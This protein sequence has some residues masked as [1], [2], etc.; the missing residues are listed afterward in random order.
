MIKTTPEF[1]TKLLLTKDIN[2]KLSLLNII[3]RNPDGTLIDELIDKT[4]LYRKTIYKY[5]EQ[6]NN[7]SEIEFNR[8]IIKTTNKYMYSFV[9]NKIDFLTIRFKLLEQSTA[10]QLLKTLLVSS[11]VNIYQFCS[12][13]YI[14]ESLFKKN[15]RAMNLF[16]LSL[17]I[18]LAIKKNE[19]YLIGNE[20]KIRYGFTTIFWRV[21]NGIYWPFNFIN[22]DKLNHIVDFIFSKKGK[23]ISPGKIE[24]L[25]YLLSINI[26]R[27][28]FKFKISSTD[29]PNYSSE[30]AA[31]SI[32]FKTLSKKLANF[33]SLDSLEIRFNL[34]MFYIFPEYFKISQSIPFTLEKIKTHLPNSYESIHKFANFAKN[35]HPNWDI[36]SEEGQVFLGS[37]ISS[38]ITIDIFKE[39]YF[40]I[41]D[42]N[43]IKFSAQNF[44]RL[45]PSISS[46]IKESEVH[47]QDNILKALSFRYAQAYML[48][49]PPQDFDPEIKIL[50]I[51]DSPLCIEKALVQ[52]V[53]SLLYPIYNISITTDYN[54]ILP[55][56]II[57][58]A[59]YSGIPLDI[60]T[61]YVFPQLD[62]RDSKN[63]LAACNQVFK[64]KN[65]D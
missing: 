6:L 37:V 55:D 58:T 3:Y 2:I 13:H 23:S 49:F 8:P 11:S 26:I 30:L 31:N 41:Q 16:F 22:L 9:G 51:T 29:L 42:L 47:I 43:L 24:L 48:A 36:N 14:S 5:I 21:Y 56:L 53:S 33:F 63:I 50:V 32:F 35:R 39:A 59:S 54:N 57:A 25:K 52:R 17:D 1:P 18:K 10:F 46:N 45:I 60:P 40:N 34:M 27:A 62:K 28:N 65:S 15:L 64:E 19:V 12:E 4:S 44:P 7:L 38:R 20:A 61:V